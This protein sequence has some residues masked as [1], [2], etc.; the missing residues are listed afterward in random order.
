[1]EDLGIVVCAL[2]RGATIP[3]EAREEPLRFEEGDRGILFWSPLPDELRSWRPAVVWDTDPKRLRRN[4]L[5]DQL[6][7][8]GLEVGSYRLIV[9][10]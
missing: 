8:I 9:E 3:T 6:K 5:L 4:V 7:L 1:M 2:R 10:C